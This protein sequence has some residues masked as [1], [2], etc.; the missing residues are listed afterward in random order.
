VR[1]GLNGG[2]GSF[3]YNILSRVG[4]SVEASGDFKNQGLSG[5]LGIYS[6]LA[7]PQIYPLKHQ[8]KLT[9][10]AH[11]LFGETFYRNDYPAYGGFPHTVSTASGFSWEAGGGFDWVHSNRWEFRLLQLDYAPTKFFGNGTKTGYRGSIGIIYRFGGK[12]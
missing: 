8:R 10:F 11:V 3:E 2:Y 5:D 4:A 6:V 1:I 12:K 9:P 7:G